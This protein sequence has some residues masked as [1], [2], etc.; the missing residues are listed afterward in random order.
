LLAGREAALR[1]IGERSKQGLA[2]TEQAEYS[3]A[4]A[5]DS[6]RRAVLQ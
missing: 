4:T 6:H 3:G 5:P 1:H 2:Y